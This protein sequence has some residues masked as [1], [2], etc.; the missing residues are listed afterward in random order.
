MA[1]NGSGTYS[2]TSGNPVVTGTTISSSWANTTLSDIATALTNSIATNGETPVVANIPLAG[3]KLTGVGAATA[4]T[5][6]ATLASIQDGTGVYVGTVG[7]TA[8]AITLTPSPAITAYAAGQ[9]FA[10]IASGANTGATTVNV[11]GLGAKSVTKAGTTALAANNILANALVEIRYDGTRFQL[12]T[13]K[14]TNADVSGLGTAATQNTGTSGANVPLLD[15]NNVHSGTNDFT[16][17]NSG[18][19]IPCQGRLTLTTA[20]PVTTADVTAATTLYFTPYKGNKV[21]LYDGTSK[22]KV[23]GISELSIA[24]PATTSTMYD[25]FVYDNA[26]TPTLELT[27]WTNDTTRATAL[28]TQNGV[29]VKTGATTRLYVGSF[30]TT[31][32]SGQTEDSNTKRYVWNYHNRVFRRM[33]VRD[34][35]D[36]W[37]Y[38]TAA[39]RQANGNAANQLDFIIG[40]LEDPVTATLTVEATTSATAR[41][42]SAGLKL[43]ATNGE[44]FTSG[45]GAFHQSTARSDGFATIVA[46]YSSYVAVG[47]HYLAWTEYGFG[48]DTQ[49]WYGDNAGSAQSG[50]VGGLWG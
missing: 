16:G 13:V 41:N 15:G 37:T 36:S 12:L 9:L 28:T 26:G 47:R 17:V 22:W 18:L 6:A 4:R 7:G 33:Y 5:D 29:L 39:W 45:N 10:F 40:V 2:L 43:D 24:I 19:V 35:T 49:T 50:V 44:D 42:V 21:G 30:R 46:L 11:S 31:G 14:A 38:S 23:Y 48:V 3:Y 25:A 32:V 8:D 1:R 20:T 27:A 34:T